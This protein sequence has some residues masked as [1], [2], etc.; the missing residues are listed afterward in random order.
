LSDVLPPKAFETYEIAPVG[1]T[2]TRN[3]IV[4]YVL[5]FKSRQINNFTILFHKNMEI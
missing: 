2:D 1:V 3:L 5:I 4:I